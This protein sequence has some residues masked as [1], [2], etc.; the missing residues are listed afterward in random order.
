MLKTTGLKPTR[1]KREV[2]SL[3]LPESKSILNNRTVSGWWRS[4]QQTLETLVKSILCV[5]IFKPKRLEI[6]ERFGGVGGWKRGGAVSSVRRE[7]ILAA[8][9]VGGDPWRGRK[10]G[11]PRSSMV[12]AK[13]GNVCD[14]G[15]GEQAGG[16]RKCRPRGARGTRGAAGAGR[17]L[18]SGL[19][20]GGRGSE[21]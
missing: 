4:T 1:E 12:T 18:H 8:K 10:E 6:R 11:G 20:A 19:R 3:H 5:C 21:A 7:K 15:G 14:G 17:R 13:G 9:S 2:D 16:R